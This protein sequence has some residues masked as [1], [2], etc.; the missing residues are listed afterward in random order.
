MLFSSNLMKIVIRKNTLKLNDEKNCCL[1]EVPKVIVH[2]SFSTSQWD[3]NTKAR[4]P[5]R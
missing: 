1:T 5:Y 4:E 3:S 2:L